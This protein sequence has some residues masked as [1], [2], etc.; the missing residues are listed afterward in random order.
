MKLKELQSGEIFTI[1]NTP[2]YPKLKLRD[3]YVDMRDEIV[4]KSS[5]CDEREVSIIEPEFLAKIFEDSTEN[6]KS[7]IK[8]IR[9]KYL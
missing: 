6:I 4:N 8:E 2:S 1:E 7:W 3:G 5:N 9:E